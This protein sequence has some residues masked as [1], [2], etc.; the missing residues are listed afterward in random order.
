MDEQTE[1]TKSQN[2][3]L[4]IVVAVLILAAAGFY[5]YSNFGNKILNQT[6]STNK[7]TTNITTVV[8]TK[9]EVKSEISP[10][11]NAAKEFTIRGGMFWFDPKNITVQKGDT[12]KIIFTNTEG[13]HDLVIDEFNV[14]TKKTNAGES[15]TV[16]FVADKMGTFEYYCSVGNHRQMGMVG[17]LVVE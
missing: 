7:P 17:K 14:A 3:P 13:T 15:D 5:L 10:N 16:Q 8:Q 9:T 12:V 11:I 6:S 4:M 1:T 2:S